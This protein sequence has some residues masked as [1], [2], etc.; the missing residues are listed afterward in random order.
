MEMGELLHK[1]YPGGACATSRTFQRIEQGFSNE[2]DSPKRHWGG[3]GGGT[4]CDF[5]EKKRHAGS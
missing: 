3:G 4:K 1:V 2:G 5:P